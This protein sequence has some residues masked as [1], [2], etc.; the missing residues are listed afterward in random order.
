MTIFG[1]GTNTLPR[2]IAPSKKIPPHK[3]KLVLLFLK[4][5]NLKKWVL[6]ST[7]GGS[8]VLLEAFKGIAASI[9]Y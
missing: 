8:Q 4:N 7:P 6:D 5:R 3:K 9:E 2:E 1:E